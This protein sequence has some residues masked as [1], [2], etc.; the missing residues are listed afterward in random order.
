MKH[1]NNF[2][3]QAQ[4]TYRAAIQCHGHAQEFGTVLDGKSYIDAYLRG[5]VNGLIMAEIATTEEVRA[6]F[7]YIDIVEKAYHKFYIEPRLYSK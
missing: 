7:N 3:K 6:C 4:I 1:Y 5:M 2:R